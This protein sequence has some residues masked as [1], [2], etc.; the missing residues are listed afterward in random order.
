MDA[1][2]FQIV[3]PADAADEKLSGDRRHSIT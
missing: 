2:A 1:N 3:Q